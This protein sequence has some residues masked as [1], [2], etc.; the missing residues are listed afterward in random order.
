LL[1]DFLNKKVSGRVL[2]LIF[3]L[4]VL[5]YLVSGTTIISDTLINTPE[6][7][8]SGNFKVNN[9]VF[10]VNATSGNVGIG[11]ASPI[12]QFHIPIKIPSTHIGSIIISGAHPRQIRVQGPYAYTVTSTGATLE[13]YDVSLADSPSLIGSIA[14][15]GNAQHIH[16]QGSYVYAA[17]NS[18]LQI[19]DVSNPKVPQIV[20]TITPA[21]LKSVYVQGNYAYLT[22]NNNNILYVISISNPSAP[23]IVGSVGTGGGDPTQV[24]VQGRYAYIPNMAADE[25]VVFDI[26]NPS[27][28][29]EIGSVSTGVNT[30]PRSV[31]VQGSYAYVVLETPNTLQIINISDPTTPSV[32]T[33]IAA[34]TDPQWVE[35]R[36]YYAYVTAETSETVEVIDVSNPMS[37]SSAGSV[38]TDVA[39]RYCYVQG[40]YLYVTNKVSNTLQIFDMGGAYIQHFEVGSF[41]AGGGNFRNDLTVNNGLDVRGNIIVGGGGLFSAG[42]GGFAGNLSVLGNVGIGTTSPSHKLN[43]IGGV[44]ITSNLIVGNS[45]GQ[46]NI[47]LYSPD[48]AAWTCGVNDAGAFS[49]S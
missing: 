31:Y 8:I 15:G 41:E 38:G 2:F 34:G 37:P 3:I 49:C 46:S 35:V 36:G 32:V 23:V 29:S 43:V 10:F 21:P 12:I 48:G 25:L 27:S 14:V 22:D 9:T 39:P 28:P 45:S 16:V 17:T 1:I 11:T 5:I 20:G 42:D 4:L 47:T 30:A 19:I 13:V 33:S 7:N 18:G 44:N 40:R 6:L 24:Y 26:S